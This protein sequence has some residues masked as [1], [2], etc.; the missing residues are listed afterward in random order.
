MV[1]EGRCFLSQ[2]PFKK[3]IKSYSLERL[4]DADLSDTSDAFYS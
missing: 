2:K 3:L 4:E 1:L